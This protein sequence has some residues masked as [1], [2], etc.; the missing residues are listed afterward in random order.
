VPV[1]ARLLATA[2]T[3]AIAL[4]GFAAPTVAQEQVSS[5]VALGDWFTAGPVI[6]N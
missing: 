2:A 3:V 4:I 6:P 5:Y 1:P